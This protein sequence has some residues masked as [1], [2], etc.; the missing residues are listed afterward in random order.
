MRKQRGQ[1]AI[2]VL[3]PQQEL[4]GL[5]LN[6]GQEIETTGPAV[7]V[8]GQEVIL[9]TEVTAE[10]R[11]FPALLHHAQGARR[12]QG[13]LSGMH[14]V[15]VTG[16]NKEIAV[17]S[18][19]T[20]EGQTFIVVLGPEDELRSAGLQNGGEVSVRGEL[21]RFPNHQVLLARQLSA[22]GHTITVAREPQGQGQ[23]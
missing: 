22:N 9:P 4:S 12:L 16:L 21:V 23:D 20:N 10:G 17:G 2:V 5:H 6:K 11:T 14:A 3:G 19:R 15:R 1:T 13:Q 18:L 7:W 8:A